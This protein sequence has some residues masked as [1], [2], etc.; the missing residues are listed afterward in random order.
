MDG[1]TFVKERDQGWGIETVCR[2]VSAEDGEVNDDT[3]VLNPNGWDYISHSI[4]LGFGKEE[5]RG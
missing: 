5:R 3:S 1:R 4:H 2:L